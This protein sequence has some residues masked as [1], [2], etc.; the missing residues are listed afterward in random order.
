MRR[1]L[2][3]LRHLMIDGETQP[4]H[5]SPEF[6]KALRALPKGPG[7]VHRASPRRLA[8]VE[9]Y[10]GKRRIADITDRDIRALV[11]ELAKTYRP[12]TV[13]NTLVPVSGVFRYAMRHGWA[14]MNPVNTGAP[15]RMGLFPIVRYVAY[16]WELLRQP[17]RKSCAA[18]LSLPSAWLSARFW[19]RLRRWQL[20]SRAQSEGV[21]T[22]LG[23]S[24]QPLR[25]GAMRGWEFPIYP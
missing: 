10:I 21:T 20:I 3:D 23:D 8:R 13:K 7:H 18:G 24:P 5:G 22:N 25:L 16:S 4:D 9:P 19:R 17:G 1:A 14:G 15:N 11:S 12:H 2:N 6:M